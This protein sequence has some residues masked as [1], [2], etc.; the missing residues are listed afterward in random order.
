[1]A[2]SRMTASTRD[3]P[4]SAHPELELAE[5]VVRDI[6]ADLQRGIR[7]IRVS[8]EDCPIHDGLYRAIKRIGV[9]SQQTIHPIHFDMLARGT[10]VNEQAIYKA[11]ASS[12]YSANKYRPREILRR[13]GGV[14]LGLLGGLVLGCLPL[15]QGLAAGLGTGSGLGQFFANYAAWSWGAAAVLVSAGLVVDWRRA[16]AT[17]VNPYLEAAARLETQSHDGPAGG[18]FSPLLKQW[19]PRGRKI[20]FVI[21]HLNWCLD[22]KIT[23]F[24]L[25]SLHLANVAI[26]FT[27]DGFVIA[28]NQDDF[29]G[30]ARHVVG[31]VVVKHMPGI[32]IPLLLHEAL[33]TTR[34]Q[35]FCRVLKQELDRLQIG[36]CAAA[37]VMRGL[38]SLHAEYLKSA[39]LRLLPALR[40]LIAS[41]PEDLDDRKVELICQRFLV[42]QVG[43]SSGEKEPFRMFVAS[44]IF[45]QNLLQDGLSRDDLHGIWR[46][47][48]PAR[49]AYGE[50]ELDAMSR[51]LIRSFPMSSDAKPIAWDPNRG[52][53]VL[54]Q[55][56]WVA[57]FLVLHADQVAKRLPY[58]GAIKQ[59][60]EYAKYFLCFHANATRGHRK[61]IE[62]CASDQER[63]FFG[64][65][66]A[67]QLQGSSGSDAGLHE[68]R[69]S[70]LV[71][72]NRL[73]ARL[74][75]S[76]LRPECDGDPVVSKVFQRAFR[77]RDVCAGVN[78]FGTICLPVAAKMF[79]ASYLDESFSID[80]V[81]ASFGRWEQRLTDPADAELYQ[82]ARRQLRRL[83][84]RY[85]YNEGLC[86]PDEIRSDPLLTLLDRI[87]RNVLVL[88]PEVADE[89]DALLP[90]VELEDL[91][92]DE[93]VL[94]AHGTSVLLLL[95]VCVLH[96][97]YLRTEDGVVR[98]RERAP[99]NGAHVLSLLLAALGNRVAELGRGAAGFLD[100]LK[101]SLHRANYACL[102]TL[103][104][105]CG[106]D[107]PAPEA[108]ADVV[109][110]LDLY[111]AT[112]EGYRSIERFFGCCECLYWATWFG[113]RG[114]LDARRAPTRGGSGSG[115]SLS[116]IFEGAKTTARIEE[117]LDR[118]VE[119]SEHRLG[120]A[121]HDTE[122][123]YASCVTHSALPPASAYRELK[124][125]LAKGAVVPAYLELLLLERLETI[126]FNGEFD[127]REKL[128][129]ECRE[130]CQRILERLGWRITARRRASLQLV[131]AR[132]YSPASPEAGEIFDQLASHEEDLDGEARGVFAMWQLKRACASDENADLARLKSLTE[133]HLRDA[134][135]HY[136][137]Y[138]GFAIGVN[139]PARVA[140]REVAEL[141]S[142][143][144]ELIEQH[145]ALVRRHADLASSLQGA[146][147]PGL[148]RNGDEVEEVER[149][150]HDAQVELAAIRKRYHAAR[151]LTPLYEELDTALE[152]FVSQT[153]FQ[154]YVSGEQQP[155]RYV[156]A[157]SS[158]LLADHYLRLG[159]GGRARAIE[160]LEA[161]TEQFLA[162]DEFVQAMECL[163]ELKYCTVGEA[164]QERLRQR[165][166]GVNLLLSR[167]E[168]TP[169]SSGARELVQCLLY[170][171][172]NPKTNDTRT[173]YRF[174]RDVEGALRKSVEDPKHLDSRL[175]RRNEIPI[176]DG[177]CA[178][179]RRAL[180]HFYHSSYCGEAAL[181]LLR[182]AEVAVACAEREW[183]T[184]T[185]SDVE[186]LRHILKQ[187]SR[188]TDSA[189]T[190]L[191]EA[192]TALEQ[193][194]D[195][196]YAQYQERVRQFVKQTLGVPA[197]GP[198]VRN[199]ATLISP[200]VLTGGEGV[201]KHDPA[202]LDDADVFISAHNSDYP[203][204][205]RVYKYL[206]DHGVSA[207]FCKQTLPE[208]GRSDF[209]SE[210]SKALERAVHLVLVTSS[211]QNAAAPWVRHEWGSFLTEELSGRK[212]GDIVVVGVGGIHEGDLPYDLRSKQVIPV[213][214]LDELLKYVGGGRS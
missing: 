82:A 164:V 1:M 66:F 60:G 43:L 159:A 102:L 95:A 96:N 128:M 53:F 108:A 24:L 199:V 201:R 32:G 177:D 76:V 178:P 30:E 55:R 152:S 17:G 141:E 110:V 40:S 45:A 169:A 198:P 175:F 52:Q 78:P 77:L 107:A 171:Y 20:V 42:D 79:G 186:S 58:W 12:L 29:V 180:I 70:T 37:A 213:E 153:D 73:L 22:E 151:D 25:T 93:A 155:A 193:R 161:A 10:E 64:L 41:E 88:L 85:H 23:R 204:A 49:D 187:V 5:Q 75:T 143:S 15:L 104:R 207:F 61:L 31:E 206:K 149:Q 3:A 116:R 150:I 202:Q 84:G 179:F 111:A 54:R 74:W 205:E 160:L 196:L 63:F 109:D 131:I 115:A 112:E 2:E 36:P 212:A 46:A 142:R 97:G 87:E 144:S 147:L 100:E 172:L 165:V 138:L 140:R 125:V 123:V 90:M 211:G 68:G 185:H 27:E 71:E 101:Y 57:D 89:D 194:V 156:V 105:R 154:R 86:T 33:A 129:Q 21:N 81:I 132:T 189:D 208:R 114:A 28:P 16:S 122:V 48:D 59:R 6:L 92:Q 210:I 127:D 146:P 9:L 148:A 99:A 184:I 126:C 174:E 181:V 120:Y 91:L 188:P 163:L 118:L 203:C 94:C 192:V 65:P 158:R 18:G 44:V 56:A 168:H 47:D 130:T 72:S 13:R 139:L 35:G 19:T 166:Q 106:V 98:P 113:I 7:V 14:V 183:G 195:A 135:F 173:N 133:A 209:A 119:I 117:M 124:K 176:F 103:C 170:D 137:Q 8:T 34:D 4:E 197:E 182:D 191:V 162:L 39:E 83:E 134:P 214:Q 145:N 67:I 80:D 190:V 200:A 11:I 157:H 26:V 50:S 38:P 136:L 69:G 51:E 62:F 121:Y 167:P